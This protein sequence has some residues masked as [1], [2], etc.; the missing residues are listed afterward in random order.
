MKSWEISKSRS[1]EWLVLFPVLDLPEVADSERTEYYLKLSA[2]YILSWV[3]VLCVEYHSLYRDAL[4]H[5][6]IKNVHEII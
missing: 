3:H 1:T 6:I 2:N 5:E 4:V